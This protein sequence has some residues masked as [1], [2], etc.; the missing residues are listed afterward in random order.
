MK[1]VYVGMSADLIHHGHINIIKKAAEL[2]QVTVGLLTDKAIGSYKRLPY[3]TYEDREAVV[4]GIKGVNKIIKQETLD[5]RPNLEKIK[6]DFVVHGDDWKNGVQAKVREQIIKK[7]SE[8]GGK[9]IDVPY[10]KNISSSKLNKAL[11]DHGTTPDRRRS[12][13]K[14]LINSVDLVRVIEAHSGISSLI[15]ENLEIEVEGRKKVFDCMWSSSLTDST[16]KGKPDI[17][18]VDVTD[19]SNTI[20]TIFEVTT[21][22]MIYDADTG[23]R[24]EH[25]A[26]TVRTLERLGVSAVI[27]EDKT[28]LKKNSLFG[29]D[30]E[31]TQDNID[32]FCFKINSG[33]NAQITEDFMIFARCE[34]LILDKGMNDAIDRCKAYLNS[35]A[36]GIMI[37]SRKSD[38]QEIM[39]FCK[40][41][42]TFGLGKPLIV[43]PSSFDHIAEEEFVKAG[44]NVVIYANHLL[45][46][47]Y[48]AM[49]K[50]ATSILKNGRAYE[51]RADCLSIK[52]ILEMIPGTK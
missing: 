31:Q 9:V 17:E 22:P 15:V 32:D 1:T 6:P 39:D 13:L 3:L 37:H 49:H 25:F 48:P 38:G 52:Q 36:D 43:V 27:I 30:V 45:R 16:N 21:K 35:G 47:A 40:E 26:Y 14:R 23:G 8:W 29:T 11:K 24:P 20:S 18:A 51:S 4:L 19:R 28:G 50:V 46:A 7:M 44:V 5:Y 33:K 41:Y 12:Q 2:G 34:S 10:T 42:K